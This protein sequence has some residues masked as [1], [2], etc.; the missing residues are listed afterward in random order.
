MKPVRLQMAGVRSWQ[1]EQELDFAQVDLAAIV[2]PTG[3]GKSSILEAIVYSLYNAT[4]YDGRNV[5]S[6]ISSDAQSIRVTFD[7]E[8]NSER[9]RVTRSTS[10]RSYPPSVHKLSCLTNPGEHPMVEGEGAVNDAIKSLIGLNVEQFTTAVLLP[11]GRFQRLLTATPA[12][13]TGILKGVFR[14]DEL[15]ALRERATDLRRDFVDPALNEAV[16][17]RA[18]LLPDPAATLA[19]ATAD[20]QQARERVDKLRV[21]QEQHQ[22]AQKHAEELTKQL[23]AGREQAEALMKAADDVPSLDQVIDASGQLD[24][25]EAS[26]RETREKQ[27]RQRDAL[28]SQLDAAEKAGETSASVAEAKH[29]LREA[30][31]RLPQLDQDQIAL[32]GDH[33]AHETDLSELDRDR[34]HHAEEVGAL[35]GAREEVVSLDA[36]KIDSEAIL[37]RSKT[38]LGEARILVKQVEDARSEV[39]DLTEAVEATQAAANSAKAEDDQNRTAVS[40]A[41]AALRTAEREHKAAVIAHDLHGG[42]ACPIC[43]RELPAGFEPLEAP[44]GLRAAEEDVARLRSRAESSAEATM[45]AKQQAEATADALATKNAAV[46]RIEQSAAT[47]LDALQAVL[48]EIDLSQSD[49]DLLVGVTGHAQAAV[50]AHKDK[51][52]ALIANQATLEAKHA[53]L[54]ERQRQLE[55]QGQVLQER[56]ERL[57]SDRERILAAVAA[58]PA[59]ATPTSM[60]PI[61]LQKVLGTCERRLEQLQTWTHELRTVRDGCEELDRSLADVDRRRRAEV[62]EPRRVA[63]GLA[64]DIVGSLRSLPTVP[65]IPAQPDDAVS[66]VKHAEWVRKVLDLARS[67]ASNLGDAVERQEV[68][69]TDAARDGERALAEANQLVDEDVATATD[70]EGVLDETRA[71]VRITES[72][73]EL[74]K[75]H[76]PKAAAL[77]QQIEALRNRHDALDELCRLLTDG[78]FVSWL[79]AR[80]QQTLLV[81]GSEILAGMT[82]QRYRFDSGF[83]IVDGRTGATRNTKTLSGGEAF[84]ASLALALGMSELAARSGGRIGSLYLDE[85]FGSLDPNTL[86]EAINALEERA[87]A[88][89]MIMVISHV[90]AVAQRIERVLQVTPDPAGSTADWLDDV[91]RDAMLTTAAAAD[92]SGLV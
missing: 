18:Q 61:A 21:C 48:G 33:A 27:L 10:R 42:D 54:D 9:W 59:M 11:Q 26:K 68:E 41:E 85:G 36:A 84:L 49:G 78:Q 30:C 12:D 7:F 62:D 14:L 35:E 56:A 89:Q 57:A 67:S 6:L 69:I 63:T 3:A 51:H 8:A 74:A 19:E 70:L 87:R 46:E 55:D 64:R 90:P 16:D 39:V 79:V 25:D 43:Q 71:R 72:N 17:S 92:A 40:E 60:T 44:A 2:G 32:A 82:D 31:E 53:Q 5:T 91:D 52:A 77:K 13:R 66:V 86:D 58:L 75:D 83:G 65:R 88:G 1:T 50:E 45:R 37:T 34:E 20:L 47:A 80:R 38:V 28:Q 81:V 29:A 76:L 4:T 22:R 24:A 15:T 23:E 73:I